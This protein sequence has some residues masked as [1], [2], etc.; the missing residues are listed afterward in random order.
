[1]H[2]HSW[3]PESVS[4]SAN[5]TAQGAGIGGYPVWSVRRCEGTYRKCVTQRQLHGA[6]RWHRRGTRC[7]VCD[8]VKVPIESV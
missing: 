4:R 7:G 6:G 2:A 3:R 5:P 8:D 1:M